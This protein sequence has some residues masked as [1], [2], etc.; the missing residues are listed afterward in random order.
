MF[1]TAIVAMCPS[2]RIRSA[3][4]VW[5]MRPYTGRARVEVCPA[6]T[7][8]MSAPAR[9]KARATST[10]VSGVMPASPTQSLAEIRTDMGFGAGHAARTAPNTRSGK[11][12][13]FSRLPP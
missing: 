11:R 3:N 8:Q 6:D 12:I 5:N 13:R 1:P 9:R 10:A 4:G 2:L 7:S